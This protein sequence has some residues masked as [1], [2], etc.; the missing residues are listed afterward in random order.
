[1]DAVDP[2]REPDVTRARWQAEDGVTLPEVL[3]VMVISL[4]VLTATLGS[5]ERFNA[6]AADTTRLTQAQETGRTQV[7][8]LDRV[9]RGAAPATGASDA[10]LRPG[11]PGGGAA[12]GN[13]LVV[14]TANWPG[15]SATSTEVRQVRYCLAADK[16]LYRE[17]ATVG[18][19]LAAASCP[20]TTGATELVDGI[21]ANGTGE[22]LFTVDSTRRSVGIDLKLRP[23]GRD[24]RVASIR[25]AAYLRSY[26]GRAPNLGPGDISATPCT[27]SGSSLLTLGASADLGPLDVVWNVVNA[28]G[29]TGVQLGTGTDLQVVAA[30]PL[31][32]SATI[33]NALGLK[34]VLTRTVTC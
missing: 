17:V 3:V 28:N 15:S 24:E 8:A 13:D 30:T 7:E 10:V 2:D 4:V 5:F 21:V 27:P 18:T 23:G 6:G 11:T 16:S 26:A 12:S 32:V 1:M 31:T 29:T 14:T 20:A 25:S 19:S 22:P 34:Q 33:T 9:L